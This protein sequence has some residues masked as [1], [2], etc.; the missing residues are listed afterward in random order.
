MRVRSAERSVVLCV[1]L[2][3]VDGGRGWRGDQVW[4]GKLGMPRRP[5][6]VGFPASPRVPLNRQGAITIGI[7]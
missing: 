1:V 2:V 7:A 6:K 4:R 5:I 3:G